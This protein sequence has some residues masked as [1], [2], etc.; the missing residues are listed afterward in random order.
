MEA[1]AAAEA[2]SLLE[3]FSHWCWLIWCSPCAHPDK[4]EENKE[5]YH[6]VAHYNINCNSNCCV[7]S[8]NNTNN[9]E[10]EHG[11]A[12]NK[13]NGDL[14]VFIDLTPSQRRQISNFQAQHHRQNVIENVDCKQ[15]RPNKNGSISSFK[16]VEQCKLS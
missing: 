4:H 1:V 7:E 13:N 8:E 9:V 3:C 10:L 5:S 6:K 15:P 2:V 16:P 11:K 12:N 14:P